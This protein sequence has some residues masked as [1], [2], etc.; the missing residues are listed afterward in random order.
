MFRCA[1]IVLVGVLAAACGGGNGGPGPGPTPIA[2]APQIACPADISMRGVLGPTQP[3]SFTAP[4]VTGGELPNTVTCSQTSGAAFPLGTSAVS[5]SVS[6]AR[7]RQAS[8]AFNVSLTALSIGVTK[9]MAVGDSFTEGQN[10]LPGLDWAFVD[11][12]NSYPTKLQGLLDL[13]YPG[14]GITV[15]NRG[16]SG[17]SVEKTVLD[18]PGNLQKDRPGAVLVLTG[19]NNL[20]D[21]CR[22][23]DGPSHPRCPRS[24]DDVVLGVRDCIRRSKEA[25]FNIPHV[26]VS[27]L[28]PPGPGPIPAGI[29][30]RRIRGD[31]ILQ[32]N[33]R[34]RTLVAAE[35]AVLADAYP[36]FVGNEAQYVSIDGLHLLPPGNQALADSFFEAIRARIPQTPLFTAR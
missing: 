8:C 29:N 26:F 31:V 35:G 36:R 19:Y 20:L 30:D 6:D 25:P 3:V 13:T 9:Y 11:P 7:G 2:S 18:L 14:Q 34:I 5:C 10:G 32:V 15:V 12:A 27:T 33:A 23:F 1:A 24:M 21:G 16:I 22:I 4:A 28:T 17:E